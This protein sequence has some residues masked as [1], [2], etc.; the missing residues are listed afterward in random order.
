MKYKS[1]SK[2][3]DLNIKKHC[4]YII[5]FKDGDFFKFGMTSDV[6]VRVLS[7]NRKHNLDLKKAIFF[8]FS[9]YNKA[10]ILERFI[11]KLVMQNKNC[12]YKKIFKYVEVRDMKHFDFCKKEARYFS[13]KLNGEHFYFRNFKIRFDEAIII[14]KRNKRET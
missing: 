6:L 3:I 7:L 12:P 10:L 11:S 4:F 1:Q 13:E 5:P 9:E 2:Q 8:R 14:G